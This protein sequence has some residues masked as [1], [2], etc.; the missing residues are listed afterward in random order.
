MKELQSKN[1][2]LALE[3]KE[4]QEKHLKEREQHEI[5]IKYSQEQIHKDTEAKES[6]QA[7]IQELTLQLETNMEI[8]R[9]FQSSFDIHSVNAKTVVNN[10]P[11]SGN[12]QELQMK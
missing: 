5:L 3:I 12:D 1:Q 6:L 7:R 11:I 2:E 8:H 9:K 4:I 10:L